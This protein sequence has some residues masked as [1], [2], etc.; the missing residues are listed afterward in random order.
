MYTE[1]RYLDITKDP[2]QKPLTKEVKLRRGEGDATKIRAIVQDHGETF[3]VS[4]YTV[5]FKMLNPDK[6]YVNVPAA[7]EDAKQGIVYCVVPHDATDVAGGVDIAY[8][9]LSQGQEIVTTNDIPIMV[10]LS[11]DL[12]PEQEHQYKT[13]IEKL[14]EQLNTKVVSS[15]VVEY[16]IGT[17]NTSV[18]SSGWK[19]ALPVAG[20]GSWLWERR[21]TTYRDGTK[22]T[23]YSYAYQGK[24]NANYGVATTTTQGL[25]SAQD[26]KDLE[27]LKTAWD[28][29]YQTFKRRG[30]VPV[31]TDWNTLTESGMFR[32]NLESEA[33]QTNYPPSANSWGVLLVF[34]AGSIIG[35]N[36]TASSYT[37]QIY[38]SL[39]DNNIFWRAGDAS[40][41]GILPS[42]RTW[43]KITGTA[44]PFE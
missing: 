9:E 33:G 8:F 43:K 13:E 32:V 27:S 11:N 3:D 25:M 39:F 18:P 15:I 44:V 42:N 37:I 1:T 36:A 22:T 23:E 2:V 20:S 4:G 12:S 10:L 5:T 26:K 6:Q 16:A 41:S 17:N 14:I 40:G 21:V 35:A 31:G 24:D 34:N 29:A 38:I 30:A 28:S 7:I 19:T